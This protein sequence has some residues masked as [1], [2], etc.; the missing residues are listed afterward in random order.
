M[1][2]QYP[3]RSGGGG[4]G[5]GRLLLLPQARGGAK[6]YLPGP[7]AGADCWQ[8]RRILPASVSEPFILSHNGNVD[9]SSEDLFSQSCLL[10]AFQ[11]PAQEP[12]SSL[13]CS[14]EQAGCLVG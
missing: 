8:S 5:G 7:H 1:K 10:K 3:P 13:R 2:A 9:M 11:E 4:G 14:S 12:K 6:V